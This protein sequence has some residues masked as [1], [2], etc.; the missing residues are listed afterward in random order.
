MYDQVKCCIS[1]KQGVTHFFLTLQGLQ[2][3]AISSPYLFALYV[4]DLPALIQNGNPEGGVNVG[5]RN[6]M[7][8]V[9]PDYLV[10]VSNAL[11]GLPSV[12]R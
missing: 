4:N 6:I 7:L 9:Y 11:E 2:Q 12:T 1:S 8:M 3:A 10:I 5:D